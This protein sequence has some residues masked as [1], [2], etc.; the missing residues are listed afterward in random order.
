[1]EAVLV[2]AP[3]WVIDSPPYNLALLKAVCKEQGHNITCLD[4]NIRFYKSLLQ[5]LE[6]SIYENPTNWYSYEYVGGIIDK[7]SKF[8][9]SCVNEIFNTN[10]RIVGFTV[11]GLS[12]RFSE[13]IAKRVKDRDSRKIIIFG[14]SHCFKT[15]FGKKLLHLNSYIDIVCYLEGERVLP[16]LLDMIEK[17]NKIGCFPGMAYRGKDSSI[18]DCGDAELIEDLNTLPFVDY[19]DFNLTDY[20]SKELPISTSRGCI[21]RCKFCSESRIWKKYRFRSAESIYKEIKF[22][23]FRYPFIKSFFFNDSLINGNIKM[24]DE[25]L[26]LLIKNKVNIYWGGQVA[27]REEMTREFILKMRNAGFSHV[28]YGL[29]SASSRILKMIG[30]GFT[31]EVAERV[32]KDTKKAGIRTDINIIIGFPGEDRQD[33]IATANFLKRNKKFIDEIFFHPLVISPGSYFYEYRDKLGIRFNNKFDPNSWYS[34]KE[35]NTLEKRLSL[36]EFYQKYIGSEG[37]SFFSISD[38]YLFIGDSYF[39]KGNYKNAFTYYTKAE[40]SNRNRLTYKKANKV[41]TGENIKL[42]NFYV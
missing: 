14:G 24:L 31:P 15:E 12:I 38:Y 39:N 2:Q 18:V 33:V 11:T 36:L 29:E 10:S 40:E 6:H 35:E 26:D 41:G 3:C 42:I 30:K 8:I 16:H 25:L 7:Y 4:F 9:D 5:N 28:S 20:I 32:I 34:T 19:S 27:I 22:Q 23:I 37:K 21:N 1:M 13:E 17:D